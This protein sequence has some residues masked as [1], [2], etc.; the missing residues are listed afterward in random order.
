MGS[1]SINNINNE[2]ENEKDYDLLKNTEKG[3]LPYIN[4]NPLSLQLKLVFNF[5][6]AEKKE[7]SYPPCITSIHKLKNNNI[8]IIIDS[9]Y[10]SFYSSNTFKLIH[11]IEPQ[12]DNSIINQITYFSLIDFI[13]LKNGDLFLWT[14]FIIIIYKKSQKTY[15]LLQ[16]INEKEQGTNY[17]KYSSYGHNQTQ[18]YDLNSLYELRNGD[19]VS[20]NSYGLKW[21]SKKD[22]KY[23]LIS[24]QKI[25][26]KVKKILEIKD[27]IFIVF[28]KESIT[29][30]TRC[31]LPSRSSTNNN[32]RVSLFNAKNR[33]EIILIENKAYFSSNSRNYERAFSKINYFLKDKYLFISFANFF[34]IYDIS[35][36][37]ILFKENGVEIEFLCDYY[38][39]LV[40][41]K[42]L[43]EVKIKIY[44]FKD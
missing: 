22:D 6:D 23:I 33:E 17:T 11:S 12:K 39:D 37:K 15:K 44:Q 34:Y 3:T 42:D 19:I 4:I 7:F 25:N 32:Y 29:Y 1:K 38:N 35:Q 36:N 40:V 16:I 27:N 21:Y 13:E 18:Y 5:E 30:T 20:C 2:I 26:M 8:G 28:Q 9:N 10:L 31:V 43:I 24:M 14:S 41:V